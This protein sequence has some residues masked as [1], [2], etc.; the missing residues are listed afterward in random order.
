MHPSRLPLAR[1]PILALPLYLISSAMQ[2]SCSGQIAARATAPD[3]GPDGPHG[4]DVGDD[5]SSDAGGCLPGEAPKLIGSISVCCTPQPYGSYACHRVSSA[6][7]PYM[8]TPCSNERATAQVD[9]FF[10]DTDVCVTESCT[11]DRTCQEFNQDVS[12]YQGTLTCAPDTNGNLTWAFSGPYTVHEVE[13]ACFDVG[14]QYCGTPYST[15]YS[16][17]PAGTSPD[18]QYACGTDELYSYNGFPLVTIR[19]LVLL[20]STCGTGPDVTFC[21]PDPL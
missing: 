8:S 16:P 19:Q 3:S 7:P 13:R 17:Y 21:S 2:T 14:V 11:G 9:E 4:D 1:L 5:V 15:G 18:P 20:S 12:E 6:Q 10:L